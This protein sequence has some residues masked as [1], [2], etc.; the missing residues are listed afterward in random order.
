MY[1]AL[2]GCT[3]VPGVRAIPH[4]RQVLSILPC[5]RALGLSLVILALSLVTLVPDGIMGQDN[6]T[7]VASGETVSSLSPSIWSVFQDKN[8]HH[9]FGSNGQG[10]FRYDGNT[11]TQF[12]T[13]HGLP[14]NHIRGIQQHQSGDLFINTGKGISRF[15]GQAFTTLRVS[16]VHPPGTGW[17]LQPDDL[18]FSGAQ[19]TGSVYR[20]DGQA[21]HQLAFTATKRGDDHYAR[22]PR[23]QNPHAKYSPYDVYTIYKDK[24]GSLWFGTADLGAV[25]Y[26][27]KTFDW[28]Y[29]DHL[30]NVPGGGSFGIRSIVEDQQVKFWF[31]NTRHRYRITT[32]NPTSNGLIDYQKETGLGDLKARIGE[33]SFYFSSII[34]DKQGDLWMTTYNDG[35][36]RHD[37]KTLTRYPVNNDAKDTWIQCIYQDTRGDLWLGT[38]SAGVFK[39]N[40]KGFV[41]FGR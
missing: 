12:T 10:V 1:V 7:A 34:T 23:D 20:Y 14:D 35:V 31:C 13:K 6:K 2:A 27:G 32:N 5:Y 17:T 26:D 39:F 19:D 29:E 30:T 16:K 28:L 41:G 38:N 22:L 4:W 36:W 11:L 24:R 33:S 8:N 18:W 9:W 15:D 25:R 3:I 37:G 40:G 21:L